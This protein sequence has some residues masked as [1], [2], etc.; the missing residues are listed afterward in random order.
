MGSYVAQVSTVRRATLHN[1]DEI[2]RKDIR[3]GDDVIVSVTGASGSL[4]IT[5]QGIAGGLQFRLA[6]QAGRIPHDPQLERRGVDEDVAAARVARQADADLVEDGQGPLPFIQVFRRGRVGWFLSAAVLGHHFIQRYKDAVAAARSA[7][8][9]RV[10]SRRASCSSLRE[11]SI[12]PR[13]S[14]ASGGLA[15]RRQRGERGMPKPSC[16]TIPSLTR[17]RP[18]CA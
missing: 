13:S 6:P 4:L 8:I 17:F 11:K 16:A 10:R 5:P 1:L 12:S 2:R 15:A 3:P 14:L 9:L 18:C 7:K